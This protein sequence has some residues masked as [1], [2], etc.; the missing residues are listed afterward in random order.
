[1][2]RLAYHEAGGEWQGLWAR[3]DG[4]QADAPECSLRGT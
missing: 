1:M 4:V 2:M 3:R